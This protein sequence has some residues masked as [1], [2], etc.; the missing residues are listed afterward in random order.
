M[1]A[2]EV[3]R[4]PDG[5]L[6]GHLPPG[7]TRRETRFASGDEE[8]VGDLVLPAGDGPFP[9]LLTVAGTGPQ[10]RYG[11]QVLADGT[12]AHH[13]RHRWVGN[14]LAAAGIAQLCWDKRGVQA[15]TGGDREPFDPPGDRDAHATVETDVADLLAAL[16]H[17]AARPEV[18]ADR[19][20]VMGTSAG[21][22]FSCR[23]AA[24]TDVPAGYA[25]WGG[26][27]QSI[28]DF[29]D[30]IYGLGV[31]Y[32][33]RGP[34]ER[35]LVEAHKPGMLT[36]A[37]HWPAEVEAARRGETTYRFTDDDGV[38][39]VRYLQRTIDEITHHYPDQFA[40]VTR[41]VLVVHGDRDVNV[42]VQQAHDSAAALRASGNDDVTLAVIRGAD[43]GMHVVAESVDDEQH[44]R[45]WFAG[46]GRGPY[47]E[48]FIGTV[49]GWM[50]DLWVRQG[51]AA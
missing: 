24:R 15:S 48:L 35:A 18:D 21:A 6:V 27:H 43:H 9:A 20:V 8:L 25:L 40:N 30:Y 38:E 19:I 5:G 2:V 17:L 37:E 32:A 14:R 11:D 50:R 26:V 33:A 36:T 23:A 13:G 7:A 10:N 41:P 12:V 31:S 28:V 51:T 16:D 39:Q 34:D 46:E 42:P 1:T 45:N 29:G 22:H 3:D 47:S 44:L 4:T 49:V